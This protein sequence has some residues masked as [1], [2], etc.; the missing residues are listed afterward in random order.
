MS[1]FERVLLGTERTLQHT[2]RTTADEPLVAVAV[3]EGR[4]VQVL[5]ADLAGGLKRIVVWA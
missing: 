5:R 1:L 3:A 2:A 4:R